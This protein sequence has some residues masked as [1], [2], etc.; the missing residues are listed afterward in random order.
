MSFASSL[1]LLCLLLILLGLCLHLGL[2][3][4]HD[5]HECPRLA[6]SL[7]RHRLLQAL[8]RLLLPG[9][10]ICPRLGRRLAL[11]PSRLSLD[12]WRL[13]LALALA[14]RLVLQVLVFLILRLLA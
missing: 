13:A 5:T 3:L 12:R 9:L 4:P 8:C 10:P 1:R 6:R 11:R 2:W 7:H 14:L